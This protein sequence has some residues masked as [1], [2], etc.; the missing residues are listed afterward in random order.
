MD[1][2]HS[3]IHPLLLSGIPYVINTLLWFA[4]AAESL[5]VELHEEMKK[6]AELFSPKS[7]GREGI[8]E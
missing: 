5:G 4:R 1:I 8:S 6:A 3:L 7:R 2:T